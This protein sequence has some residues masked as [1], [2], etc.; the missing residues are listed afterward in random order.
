MAALPDASELTLAV[1]TNCIR[2]VFTSPDMR[3]TRKTDGSVN[4]SPALR[5]R[6]AAAVQPEVF[7]VLPVWL[8]VVTM[9]APPSGPLVWVRQF[10]SIS[11]SNPPIVPILPLSYCCLIWVADWNRPVAALS[12]AVWILGGMHM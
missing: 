1:T 9:G 8:A 6:A 2:S 3:F 10:W 5:R 7:N 12:T 11:Q 4:T